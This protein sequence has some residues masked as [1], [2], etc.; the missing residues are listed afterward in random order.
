[1]I[2]RGKFPMS[3]LLGI[4]QLD[5]GEPWGYGEIPGLVQAW[6]QD[7]G[8]FA[9]VGLIVY[10]IYAL[11]TPTDKSQ[12]E[13]LRV[14][15]SGW[16]LALAGLALVA[17][18]AYLGTFALNPDR[19]VFGVKVAPPPPP[20]VQPGETPPVERPSLHTELR[21]MLL[22]LAGLFALLGIGE[23]FARDLARIVRRNFSFGTGGLRRFGR[24]LRAYAADLLTPNR[25]IALV[26]ALVA[27]ALV[28]AALFLIGVPR[29][30]DIWT[31]VLLVAL[32][33][34]VGALLLL[35]LF[36]AE[37]PVWAVAKLSFKEAVRSQV[38][39]IF[40]IGVLPFLFPVQW[41][42]AGNIKPSDELRSMTA[43]VTVVLALLTLIPAVLVTS[44]GIPNDIK[45]LNIYTVVSKPVLRFE[46]VL[47]RFVG[48]VALMSLVMAALTGVSLV[49]IVNSSMSERA[50][51]ET[52][53]ARV[54]LRGKLGFASIVGAE[55]QE[56]KEFEGT[57]VGREFDYRRYISGHPESPQRVIWRFDNL[58][59]DLRNPPGDRIRVEFTFDVFKLTKGEQD[60]GVLTKFQFVTHNCPLQQ[61]RKGVAEW[62]WADQARKREYLRRVE[63]FKAQ[64]ID[65]TRQ[66]VA[67]PGTPGWEAV[68]KLAEEFGYYEIN[69]KEVF[70]YRVE[71]VEIP[72][73]LVRNA[74]KGDPG[75]D[76][77][78]RPL[79]RL[80]IYVKCESPGQLL[81][82]AEPDLYLLRSEMPYSV[83]FLKASVGLWCRLCIIVGMAVALSTYLSGIL[84]LLVTALIFGAGFF[85]DF[86][87]EV[88]NSR[89]VGGGPFQ[90]MS[91][92]V[93]A[94]QPTAQL[95]DSAGT[96]L[97]LAG[98]KGVA[99]IVRRVQN[100]IPDVESFS[101]GNFVAEG[102]NVSGEYLVV[103]LLVTLGYL[104]PW[105]ILAYYLMK[106]REVAA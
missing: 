67:R 102:F 72:A 75:K 26:V 62:D 89:N 9:A 81:G 74:M 80:S 54:P 40:L 2:L 106:S 11:S 56:K 98:D 79:P 94:E 38:L 66:D 101:W 53:T 30:T 27:Y 95:S 8:G 61:P 100:M 88:A 59:S 21:P 83:N 97:V 15:V 93:K 85:T 86:I 6:L 19:V 90:S 99:W 70:D 105:A 41:L 18:A 50:K 51:A 68:N 46:I 58:P 92:V 104:L 10:L 77:Q 1:M 64:G 42:S 47:G 28:G 82:A 78:G 71:S 63:E 17:Y 7:A 3:A 33:V 35:M 43:F 32:G 60:R 23:P 45:N 24:S 29:L 12:S 52:Y 91:Q 36:E 4:L 65:P 13:K 48:Y 49:L 73:G 34:F 44:F 14:P 76:A 69:G 84:S 55:R 87:G 20:Q 31:G 22:A 5:R 57:N 39:W 25:V 37:G 96:K 103:N 16:M